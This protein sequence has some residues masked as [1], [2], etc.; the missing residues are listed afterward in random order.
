MYVLIVYDG[1]GGGQEGDVGRRT[2]RGGV[3]ESHGRTE[4]RSAE[5]MTGQQ[6][7]DG[8]LPPPPPR[9]QNEH[10]QTT[11]IAVFCRARVGQRYVFSSRA[12]SGDS[13]G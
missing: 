4:E 6:H 8:T 13:R 11:R 3:W 2:A 1:G 9:P 5:G 12:V 10:Q 7:G